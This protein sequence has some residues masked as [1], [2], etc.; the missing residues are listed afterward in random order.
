M[1]NKFNLANALENAGIDPFRAFHIQT[2]VF[3]KLKDGNKNI[4]LMNQAEKNNREEMIFDLAVL[5]RNNR[6]IYNQLVTHCNRSSNKLT[7]NQARNKIISLK[8]E[9]NKRTPKLNH[10]IGNVSN[11]NLEVEQIIHNT[12]RNNTNNS[13]KSKLRNDLKKL[14]TNNIQVFKRLRSMIGN[15]T[16]T[17]NKISN[18]IKV[19]QNTESMT[20]AEVETAFQK[21]LSKPPVGGKSRKIYTGQ[22]GGKYYYKK[23]N[24]K[25]VKKYI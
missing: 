11:M 5:E 21:L 25:M 12:L 2:K 4:H 14:Y 3:S 16:L 6:N 8:K 7:L 15:N 18:M 10:S 1:S 20:N 23:V 22:R 24:N 9:R 19:L 17:A 13:Q